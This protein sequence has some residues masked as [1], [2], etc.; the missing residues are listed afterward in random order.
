MSQM[1]K[2]TMPLDLTAEE[3]DIF[4][5][6]IGRGG[7]LRSSKPA[8]TRG[9]ALQGKAAYVWRMLAFYLSSRGQDRCMPVMADCDIHAPESVN[10]FRCYGYAGPHDSHDFE[11]PVSV[12]QV[13]VDSEFGGYNKDIYTCPVHG[14]M[15]H[16][17]G[18]GIQ[19]YQRK[20]VGETSLESRA[21]ACDELEKGII[22][23][24]LKVNKPS[25]NSGLMAYGRAFGMIDSSVGSSGDTLKDM[26]S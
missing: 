6:I 22:N 14:E 4:Q 15:S 26:L 9:N 2:I 16:G 18:P 24:V 3:R 11:A 25:Y 17:Y 21:A 20:K 10:S 8:V 19:I 13:R 5:L 12:R 23:K 7:C 1:P